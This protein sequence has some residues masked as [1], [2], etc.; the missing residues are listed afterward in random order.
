MQRCF[1][2]NQK[3]PAT[4]LTTY[5]KMILLWVF[6]VFCHNILFWFYADGEVIPSDTYNRIIELK[7]MK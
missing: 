2:T 4:D 5:A 3:L 7:A 6:F 1:K